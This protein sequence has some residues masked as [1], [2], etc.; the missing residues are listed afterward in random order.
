MGISKKL[1]KAYSDL[2]DRRAKIVALEGDIKALERLCTELENAE[3]VAL[4]RQEHYT[5]DE[6]DALQRAFR[7]E[8]GVIGLV[9]Q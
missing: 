4:F 2:Q 7:K 9:L 5:S 8:R 3:V 6:F 1:K